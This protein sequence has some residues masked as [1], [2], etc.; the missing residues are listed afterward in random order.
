MARLIEFCDVRD[1]ITIVDGWLWRI[2]PSE[3]VSVILGGI[4][5]VN[6][7]LVNLPPLS[8]IEAGRKNMKYMQQLS[9][10]DQSVTLT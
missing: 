9:E 6:G 2:R 3:E 5:R 7:S 10:L 4:Q 1:D 8:M